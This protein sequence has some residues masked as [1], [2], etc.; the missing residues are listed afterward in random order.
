MA[1]EKAALY[2]KDELTAKENGRKIEIKPVD[3]VRYTVPAN[4]YPERMQ[5]KL[6]VRFRVGKV[7]KNCYV[8]VYYGEDRII[9]KKR[10]VAAPGE[11]EEVILKKED[12]MKY[13]DLDQIVVKI[14]EA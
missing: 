6:T 5:D 1:G 3:G 14:E 7:F 13:P 11:M 12:I 2:I 9:H 8:S 10:P 4:I